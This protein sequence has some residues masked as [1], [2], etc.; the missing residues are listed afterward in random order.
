MNKS[1]LVV[2]V[3]ARSGLSKSDAARAVAAFES[4]VCDALAAGDAVN[5]T[6]FGTFKVADV[7]ERTGRNP[8]TGEQITIAAHKSA[9]F[10][11]GATL[12]AALAEAN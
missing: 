9:K 12:K 4:T 8:K 3:S 1:E 10:K 7:A 5:I 6:G 2:A 11:A